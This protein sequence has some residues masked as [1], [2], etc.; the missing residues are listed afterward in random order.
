MRRRLDFTPSASAIAHHLWNAGWTWIRRFRQKKTKKQKK[1]SVFC[2]A[3]GKANHE[4]ERERSSSVSG[5]FWENTIEKIPWNPGWVD[6]C[7][8]LYFDRF[9]QRQTARSRHLS[10]A[11]KQTLDFLSMLALMC[12]ARVLMYS[13]F[14]CF[15]RRGDSKMFRAS[16]HPKKLVHS[17][18]RDRQTDEALW[19]DDSPGSALSPPL[20][21][22]DF[23]GDETVL[24]RLKVGLVQTVSPIDH[25]FVL[26]GPLTVVLSAARSRLIGVWVLQDLG[27]VHLLLH[28]TRERVKNSTLK[29]HL[30]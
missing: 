1:Q 14:E 21:A 7:V 3:A 19:L 15:G 26:W 17:I 18:N 10:V 2:S 13:V 5:F 9:W 8:Q 30:K 4:R 20:S 24:S 28:V 12:R 22:V 6:S 25:L 16:K 29:C 11:A 23:I 27:D